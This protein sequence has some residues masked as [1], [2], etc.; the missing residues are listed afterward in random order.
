MQRLGLNELID[1]NTGHYRKSILELLDGLLQDTDSSALFRAF[2]SLKL[3]EI[4]DMRPAEWG[5]QW[6]PSATLHLQALKSLGAQNLHSGEWLVTNLVDQ[7]IG[8]LEEYFRRVRS[9]SFEKEARFFQ[10]LARRACET[11][12]D[13]AG[14][15]DPHGETVLTRTNSASKEYW[16]WSG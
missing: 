14:F 16:G 11:G 13:F 9:L 1:S 15:V 12:F 8:P 2:V 5:L 3:F 6:S 7:Y 4:A 10:R